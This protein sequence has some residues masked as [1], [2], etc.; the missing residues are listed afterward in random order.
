[1]GLEDRWGCQA[2]TATKDLT[3]KRGPYPR[4]MKNHQALFKAMVS[5]LYWGRGLLHPL[6]AK[7]R[8]DEGRDVQDT[9]RCVQS[10]PLLDSGARG[11]GAARQKGVWLQKTQWKGGC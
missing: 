9:G 3:G 7:Y 1:M 4:A 11:S 2:G 5:Y 6:Q 10:P 8:I